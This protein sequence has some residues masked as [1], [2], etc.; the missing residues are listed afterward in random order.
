MTAQSVQVKRVGEDRV[1]DFDFASLG[2]PSVVI[3]SGSVTQVN[4]QRVNGSTDLTLEGAPVAVN[5]RLQQRIKDGTDGEAYKLTATALDQAGNTLVMFGFL[6]VSDGLVSTT[7]GVGVDSYL[8][9]ASADAYW[10]D[11]HN[12]SWCAATLANREKALREATQYLDAT[13]D[14][15]GELA[16][17]NQPLG[18]PRSWASTAKAGSC[19]A[20]PCAFGKPPASWPW[21]RW[22]AGF[23]RRKRAAET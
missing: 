4:L 1:Y 17:V 5:S 11:R 10:A 16:D 19:R 23:C 8:D 3:Q 12:E 21:R 2:D 18:W 6:E 7:L 14:W 15:V 9:L 22:R 20:F 13:Y